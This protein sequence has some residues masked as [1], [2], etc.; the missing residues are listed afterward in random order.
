[1]ATGLA[2][3]VI[4]SAVTGPVSLS[5]LF[6]VL[7]TPR[8]K[9]VV[10]PVQG[11]LGLRG[12]HACGEVC[13]DAVSPQERPSSGVPGSLG[14]PGSPALCDQCLPFAPLPGTAFLSHPVDDLT[15]SA[16]DG[17]PMTLHSPNCHQLLIAP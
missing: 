11:G 3:S 16:Q 14:G 10:M 12:V 13:K 6:D 7:L 2:A 1:M 15:W 17:L 9:N 5:M 4:C 8:N